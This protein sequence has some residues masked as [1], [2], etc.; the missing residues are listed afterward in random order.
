MWKRKTEWLPWYRARNYKGNLTEAEKRQLDAFR[1]QPKHPAATYDDLPEE[2]QR[3][4]SNIQL[5]LYD[6]K[7]D[8]LAGQA[9][10]YSAIGGGLLLLNYKSCF[11][12]P[13]IWVNSGAVLL[14]IFAWVRYWWQWHKNAEEFTPKDAPWRATEEGIRKEFELN[15]IAWSRNKEREAAGVKRESQ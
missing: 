13:D 3:Y 9:F 14:V 2:A 8:G 6:R 10:L 4:L 1:T 7:Q 12:A 11:A 15:Y 5:E